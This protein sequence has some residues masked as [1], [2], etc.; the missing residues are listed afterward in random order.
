MLVNIIDFLKQNRN[1]WWSVKEISE[2]VDQTVRK[3]RNQVADLRKRNIVVWRE[4]DYGGR[5]GIVTKYKY[6][7]TG[8]WTDL[9]TV[10]HQESQIRQKNI[11]R[12]YMA[13]HVL[14]SMTIC[15]L[16]EIKQLLK[17]ILNGKQ[18]D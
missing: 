16:R 7:D 15:E 17:E 1:D 18:Q 9:Q 6:I 2:A 3:T 10:W 5:Q 4:I 14:Q 12:D 8:A 11:L 13:T